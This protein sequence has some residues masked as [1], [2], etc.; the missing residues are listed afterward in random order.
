MRCLMAKVSARVLGGGG[1]S[2]AGT[3]PVKE[4]SMT[5]ASTPSLRFVGAEIETFTAR[6]D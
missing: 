2:S 1:K 3:D 6:S 4:P 5:S